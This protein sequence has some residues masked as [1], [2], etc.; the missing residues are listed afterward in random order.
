M[1]SRETPVQ[2]R[3]GGSASGPVAA[4]SALA[5][6]GIK[7]V[8]RLAA[9]MKVDVGAE[10]ALLALLV[11]GVPLVSGKVKGFVDRHTDDT[12]DCAKLAAEWLRGLT[13]ERRALV[14]RRAA[15]LWQFVDPSTEVAPQDVPT[16]AHNA[17]ERMSPQ[18]KAQAAAF[19][20]LPGGSPAEAS[21][22]VLHRAASSAPAKGRFKVR[23][24]YDLILASDTE[25]PPQCGGTGDALGLSVV[26]PMSFD[27]GDPFY[28]AH[29]LVFKNIYASAIKRATGYTSA[30]ELT[31]TYA[32]LTAKISVAQD[33][34]LPPPACFVRTAPPPGFRVISDPTTNDDRNCSRH[35]LLQNEA[36]M[37]RTA[38][39]EQAMCVDDAWTKCPVMFRVA[40]EA[41]ALW[42]VDHLREPG[43]ELLQTATHVLM[44]LLDESFDGDVDLDA[45]TA[46]DVALAIC[47]ICLRES[48]YTD[49][50]GSAA[51]D[52][53]TARLV[54]LALRETDFDIGRMGPVQRLRDF[55]RGVLT[56]PRPQS[57]LYVRACLSVAPDDDGPEDAAEPEAKMT[58][59]Y[60]LAGA[61][62]SF[63]REAGS[64][65][66]TFAAW[67]PVRDILDRASPDDAKLL[68]GIL[69]SLDAGLLGAWL[70]RVISSSPVLPPD[71]PG[72]ALARFLVP[73]AVALLAHGSFEMSVVGLGEEESH[74]AAKL[75]ADHAE[76]ANLFVAA[77]Q[78]V[79]ANFGLDAPPWGTHVVTA[80]AV[81]A[82]DVVGHIWP[83][84]LDDVFYI[85]TFSAPRLHAK[86]ANHFVRDV[87]APSVRYLRRRQ[88]G[89]NANFVVLHA[90]GG[91]IDV[92]RLFSRS[93][94]Q[95][96]A[97]EV[98][99]WVASVATQ[100]AG[101]SGG[102]LGADLTGNE[103]VLPAEGGPHFLIATF[104]GGLEFFDRVSSVFTAAAARTT[105]G[106]A[107]P[108][109]TLVLSGIPLASGDGYG[110]QTHRL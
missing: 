20:T 6:H 77:V 61:A 17:L 67:T 23:E 90:D 56:P 52:V 103:W 92:A 106:G 64:G 4:N 93:R 78:L 38:I 97:S 12:N 86:T 29:M 105:V 16:H 41:E 70:Q 68:T 47:K 5:S 7:E 101:R 54:D 55:V 31:E 8:R 14:D 73:Q 48:E 2:R 40:G 27:K 87:V 88:W 32:E 75:L 50:T 63:P 53:H 81:A 34:L 110:I 99:Q 43:C 108:T 109:K 74:A 42:D 66:E 37:S 60:D 18:A 104:R 71:R 46:F 76:T 102:I 9:E 83:P 96:D 28:A 62:H 22:L 85:G 79:H 35:G 51:L 49:S 1:A 25:V 3:G 69:L 107:A 21:H 13:D 58:K 80:E 91:T 59:A 100:A 11:A 24:H 26:V 36:A 65:A 82:A 84:S 39:G 44:D 72:P 45:G 98:Q 95:A 10:T 94:S 19:R 33:A 89:T 30:S 57:L 15:E